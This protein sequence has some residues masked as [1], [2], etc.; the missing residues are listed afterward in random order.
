MNAYPKVF[1]P[2]AWEI[3]Y[4]YQINRPAERMVFVDKGE[5]D[6]GAYGVVAGT[7]ENIEGRAVSNNPMTRGFSYDIPPKKHSNGTTFSFADG[8]AGY[9]KWVNPRTI[10]YGGWPD[11]TDQTCNQDM[12]WLQK[13]VW[14]RLGYEDD[15]PPDCHPEF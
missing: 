7:I 9:R 12:M 11:T 14:G 15:L 1:A 6:G 10:N 4:N 13:A 8:H 5:S 2:K 3:Y